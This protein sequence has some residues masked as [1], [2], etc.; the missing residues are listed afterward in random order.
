MHQP[1]VSRDSKLD[2]EAG[3]VASEL[4]RPRIPAHV[5]SHEMESLCF[6]RSSNLPKVQ[7]CHIACLGTALFL[8]VHELWV[9]SHGRTLACSA[10]SDLVVNLITLSTQSPVVVVLLMHCAIRERWP[11]EPT[12]GCAYD[13]LR[14]DV[15]HAFCEPQHAPSSVSRRLLHKQHSLGQSFGEVEAVGPRLCTEAP[16]PCPGTKT[17]NQS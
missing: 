16:T 15:H 7:G 4:S 9:P 5:S 14:Y 2:G 8:G 10:N 12:P 17:D 11:E 1:S 6:G 3:E 13:T